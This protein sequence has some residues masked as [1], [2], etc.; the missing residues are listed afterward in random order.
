MVKKYT[1][2]AEDEEILGELDN[3]CGVIQNKEILRDMI[4]YIKLKQNNEID[5]EIGRAHV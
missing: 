1:L 3:L 2:D 4:L 5:F